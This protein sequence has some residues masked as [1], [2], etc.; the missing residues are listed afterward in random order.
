MKQIKIDSCGDCP[1][2]SK[3]FSITENAWKGECEHY[4][5][6]GM[7]LTDLSVIH[8]DCPLDNVKEG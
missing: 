4:F 8:P 2:N 3:F 5:V 1:L 7:E 6:E